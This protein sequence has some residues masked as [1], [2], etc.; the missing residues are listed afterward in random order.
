VIA[1]ALLLAQ[2]LILPPAKTISQLAQDTKP[3]TQLASD[4]K[5]STPQ[6]KLHVGQYQIIVLQDAPGHPK[7]IIRKRK[8]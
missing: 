1:V 4:W 3:S 5:P 2:Q 8:S 6:I 7:V